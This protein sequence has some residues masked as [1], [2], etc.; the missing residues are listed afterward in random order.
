MNRGAKGARISCDSEPIPHDQ[1]NQVAAWTTYS[2]RTSNPPTPATRMNPPLP[3]DRSEL[4][5]RI[6]SLTA[7][8]RE[9]LRLLAQGLGN[10]EMAAQLGRTGK[11]IDTHLANLRR[12]LAVRDRVRLAWIGAEAE[13]LARIDQSP[14]HRAR[15]GDPAEGTNF[16]DA[17]SRV[18][19][20]GAAPDIHGVG[21]DL[22]RARHAI[23]AATNAVVGEAYLRA[24]V[25]ALEIATGAYAAAIFELADDADGTS[26]RCR[27]CAIGGSLTEV[28]PIVADS[29]S[30]SRRRAFV[31]LLRPEL[32]FGEATT[33]SEH[34]AAERFA[35][36]RSNGPG[37]A[38]RDRVLQALVAD[39]DAELRVVPLIELNG[40]AIGILAMALPPTMIE[41]S[42]PDGL[43][44][45]IAPR[46][47]AEV[48][49]LRDEQRRRLGDPQADT[50]V[51][52]AADLLSI[53]AP[54]G[55]YL[56][57]SRAS[58]TLLGYRSDELLGKSPYDF[59]DSRDIA[60][61]G[62]VHHEVLSQPGPVR[63]R[64]AVRHKDGR[65]V[66]VES[67]TQ[68]VRGGDGEIMQLVVTTRDVGAEQAR[69]DDL[70]E[71]RATLE[72]RVEDLTR[73][74]DVAEQRWRSICARTN[75]YIVILDRDLRIQ[76]I[77]RT[78]AD[79][80]VDQTVGTTVD[81]HLDPA[82]GHAMELAREVMRTG[83]DQQ[84]EFET[85]SPAGRVRWSSKISPLIEEGAIVGAICI[86]RDLSGERR[87]EEALR[88]RERLYRMLFEES[89][90]GLLVHD[91][92][93][94][95]LANSRVAALLGHPES[96][97]LI[98]L[99]VMQL[100]E[101]EFRPLVRRRI[102]ALLA[103]TAEQPRMKQTLLTKNG[104][105][106][107]LEVAARACVHDGRPAVLTIMRP[108]E[109]LDDGA[110]EVE[111]RERDDATEY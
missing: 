60:K 78:L 17:D 68:A 102:A 88:E 32:E 64:Y 73:A 86:V 99:P 42:A 47:A 35:P 57:A 101:P 16:I 43:L 3:Y 59:M 70:V 87:V 94:V 14:D 82:H 71:T 83:K 31:G 9:V 104:T 13:K 37:D 45:S 62:H 40:G 107:V 8:E 106:V 26:L 61:V 74:L 91:G 79:T 1:R 63:V 53:H 67:C 89:P 25:A 97:S 93:L 36:A 111:V 38:M 46:V 80:T 49:R 5:S 23:D 77:N 108:A 90:D 55:S 66:W 4:L 27:A 29:T 24:L 76:Y 10:A 20:R 85:V 69:L 103:G 100:V 33:S 56:Y 22:E 51:N 34:D 44:R 28:P 7:R 105:T 96:G 48:A 41:R 52:H 95:R 109:L 84:T 19:P 72:H 15:R 30:G 2:V 12:K 11:T 50:L 39:E 18:P 21:D 92:N 58:E 75:D 6:A 110:A 54:G 81:R 98:G 65:R